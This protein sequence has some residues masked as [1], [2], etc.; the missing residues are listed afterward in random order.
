MLTNIKPQKTIL[1]RYNKKQKSR[2]DFEYP[3]SKVIYDNS[4]YGCDLV[5]QLCATLR[6]KTRC[7]KWPHTILLGKLRQAV[8]VQ[9]RALYNKKTGQTLSVTSF[10]EKLIGE[11]ELEV[12]KQVRQK[13]SPSKVIILF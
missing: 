9:A 13:N 10:T 2:E 6:M 8:A 4:M 3:S 5:G 11:L 12:E 7:K 1:S